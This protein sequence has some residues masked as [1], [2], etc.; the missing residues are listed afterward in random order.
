MFQTKC[1]EMNVNLESHINL[2]R[3]QVP[4]LISQ[5]RRWLNGSFFAASHLSM[6][7]NNLT[8]IVDPSGNTQPSKIWLHLSKLSHLCAQVLDSCRDAVPDLQPHIL[9]VRFGAPMIDTKIMRCLTADSGLPG[10]L[11]RCIR[12]I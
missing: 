5:R 1:V 9:L 2:L 4:E 7:C 3:Y 6:C 11:L 8:D 12:M 10:Q